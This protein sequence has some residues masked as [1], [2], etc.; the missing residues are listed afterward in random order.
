MADLLQRMEFASLTLSNRFALAPMTRTSAGEDGVPGEL[1]AQHYERYATGGF[2]L[3]I[4]EGTY[5]D[6][7]A[8]QGYANQPGLIDD[9]QIQGWKAVVDRVHAAGSKMVVQLM[10]S[11]AQLQSNRFT[12]PPLAPSAVKPRGVP[13][14]LYGAQT[15]W[16]SPKSMSASD[17]QGVIDGYVRS[18]VNAR[19]AGFDG[20]EVHG[21]NGY[22]LHEFIS[23]EFNQRSDTYGGPL[24]NRLRLMADVVREVRAAVG[25]DFLLGIRLS[26]STVTDSDYRLPEGQ[27]GFQQIV[28]A[29]ADAGVD[30]V[31]TVDLDIFGQAFVDGG[32]SL[33]DVAAGVEGVDLI[34]NGGL[35][36]TNS[37]A[38]AERYPTALLA[39]GKKALANPDFVRRLENGAELT[40]LDF[41]MLLPR[42]T[43]SNELAWRESKSAS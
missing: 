34:V 2:G 35:D 19:E 31:H 1:M 43:V 11:G 14:S 40:D 24:E 6:D 42:A 33:A 8:S 25:S 9:R 23:T 10:H 27:A 3:L 5:T 18:A 30:Y 21:A 39:I 20:A 26:Q 36:E 13:L 12:S 4:T 15:E 37:E 17:I 28:R 16:L 29:V 38:V 41:E 32:G 22:L 7:R